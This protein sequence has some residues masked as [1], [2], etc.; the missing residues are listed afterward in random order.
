MRFRFRMGTD[1][2]VGRP[3]DGW[4]IDDV[5]VQSCPQSEIM[6]IDGFEDLLP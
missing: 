3:N 4:F 1:G 2:T 6:L 5:Q